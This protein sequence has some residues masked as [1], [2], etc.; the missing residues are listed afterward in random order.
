[1]ATLEPLETH[2]L[3]KGVRA[4]FVE[5][6]NGL[7]M[8][9]LEAG[10]ETAGR[11]LVVLLHGFPELAYSWRKVMG[12]LADAGFHVVAPDLRGYGRTTGWSDA[13]DQD[14]RPFSFLALARDV[15]A[16]VQALGARE[17][18]TLVGH[19][20]GSPL[21]AWCALTRPDVFTSVVLMSA[22]FAGVTNLLGGPAALAA[23]DAGNVKAADDLARLPRPRTHYQWYY[24]TRAA[25][26]DMQF[27]PQG[28]HDFLRAYFHHKSADWVENKPFRLKDWSADEM[29]KMP[30]Y[31]IMDAGVT[32][33]E[34]VAS[35]LP[36]RAEIDA[37]RWMTEAEMAVYAG[38]YGRT[39]FQGGLNW[40]R[41]R[42]E[43][44]LVAEQSLFAG[45]TID[46]P[47]MFIAGA[48]D[49]GIQQVPG[50]LERMQGEACTRMV[51]CH[52]IDGAGHWVMQEQ[53][54]RV[55]DLLVGF[56]QGQAV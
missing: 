53:P 23:F 11:P 52:L 20:F 34:T 30:T 55:A 21:A 3:P 24:A 41:T 31:Y 2:V 10:F 54:K 44:Q 6:V 4:R 45:R 40:Y 51:E 27:A 56:C 49:W 36:P 33:A 18:A 42:F 35:H 48:S 14:L 43:A 46:V 38:E 28:V 29:A 32:M 7:S 1:M 39:G 15:V 37:C 26:A 12:P 25:N 13:Y 8:H 22:P 50:A 47:S 17:V 5:G 9:V 19:D 16:L